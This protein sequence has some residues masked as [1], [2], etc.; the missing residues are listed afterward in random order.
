M[1]TDTATNKALIKAVSIQLK[2]LLIMTAHAK[3][4]NVRITMLKNKKLYVYVLNTHKTVSQVQGL[5]IWQ[6]D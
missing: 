3:D 6:C 2:N 4:E 5:K 1:T